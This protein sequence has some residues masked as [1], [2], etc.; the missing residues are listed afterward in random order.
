M[1]NI[2]WREKGACFFLDRPA[3]EKACIYFRE[4]RQVSV[5]SLGRSSAPN[6]AHKKPATWT[7]FLYS[8]IPRQ[9]HLDVRSNSIGAGEGNRTLVISLGSW[10]NAIIRHPLRAADF[11]PDVAGKLKFFFAISAVTGFLPARQDVVGDRFGAGDG[12]E[13]AGFEVV[14]GLSRASLDPAG[15]EITCG[16][17]LLARTLFQMANAW[18]S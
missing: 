5:K 11:V 18:W 17:R 8:C 16:A 4:G 14:S 2:Q 13:G 6:P 9:K 10:S 15:N 3:L 1:V 7:G 12:G